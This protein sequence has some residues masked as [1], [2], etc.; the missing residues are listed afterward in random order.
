MIPETNEKIRLW[1]HNAR[2]RQPM[3]ALSEQNQY[4][5]RNLLAGYLQ[6]C[7]DFGH[8]THED[9]A[10]LFRELAE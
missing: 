7:E 5:V 4:N 10:A 1:F 2:N 9:A 6:S 3:S 8:I